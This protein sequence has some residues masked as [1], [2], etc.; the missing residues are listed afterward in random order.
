MI[1]LMFLKKLIFIKQVY[2]N[3]G[4][5]VLLVFLDKGFKFQLYVCSCCHDVLMMSIK[6]IDIAILNINDANYRCII[7]GAKL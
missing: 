4:I 6:L 5:F 3:S 7:N 1:E 2:Q